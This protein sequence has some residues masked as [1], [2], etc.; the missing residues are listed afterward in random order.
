MRVF[1][2]KAHDGQ[3]DFG[4]ETNK[5]LFKEALKNSEGKTFRI[6]REERKRSLSQN[7]FYWLYLD[8]IEME[9]GNSAVD[10]HEYFKRKILPPK[11]IKVLGEEIEVPRSTTGLTKLEFG[12]YLEKICALTEIP[13]PDPK[14]AGFIK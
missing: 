7:N 6:V 3:I 8:M 10:L 13:L 4:S 14:A 12:E 5:A 9:T 2:F 1:V 11:I